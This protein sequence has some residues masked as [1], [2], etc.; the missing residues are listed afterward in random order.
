MNINNCMLTYTGQYVNILEPD[1]ATIN[2]SDIAHALSQINRFGGHT[3]CF[4]SVAQHCVLASY[5]VTQKYQMHTLLHVAAEAYYGDMIHPLKHLAHHRAYRDHE[6]VMQSLIYE[7]FGLG[8][9]QD[10]ECLD[11]VRTAD[12]IMLATERRDLMAPDQTPWAI[13]HGIKPA[14]GTIRPMMP[15]AAETAFLKRY[16]ELAGVQ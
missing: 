10:Q 15:H 4:Y 12:L 3:R 6:S 8:R 16:K 1:P 5:L 2:I 14:R 7:R 13:L 9:A 11:I